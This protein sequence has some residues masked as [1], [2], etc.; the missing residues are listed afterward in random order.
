MTKRIWLVICAITIIAIG[1]LYIYIHNSSYSTINKET[2]NNEIN[3]SD[4]KYSVTAGTE[5]Y[6]GFILDNVLHTNDNG[7]IHYNVYIPD[8]YDGSEAYALY[9][10]LPGYQGLYFQGVGENLQTEEFGFTAQN[11]NSKMI[12]VVPQLEDWQETSANQTIELVEYFISNYNIDSD[13]VYANGY[14]GG[15]ETMSLVMAKRSELFSAYLHCSSRWDGDYELVVQNR[16]PVYFVIGADD[17]YYG[18]SP[19]REAYQQLHDLY[20]QAGLSNQE[21]DQLLILDIKDEQYFFSQGV[22]YQHAG[23][24]LFTHDNDIMSWLFSH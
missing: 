9:F 16:V 15:G 10:T 18:S 8:S 21:I 6:R 13:K 2:N 24:N 17:E 19:T 14:S 22:T 4:T 11:Y 20:Q 3:N 7:D 23:G 5:E 1:G 12:I